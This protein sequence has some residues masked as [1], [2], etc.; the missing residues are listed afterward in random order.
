MVIKVVY[1]PEAQNA[2]WKKFNNHFCCVTGADIQGG[3]KK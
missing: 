3:P 1:R 2:V